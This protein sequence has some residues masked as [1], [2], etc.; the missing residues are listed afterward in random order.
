M[1]QLFCS[2]E[3]FI[4]STSLP[5]VTET[6]NTKKATTTV[7]PPTR[8]VVDHVLQAL[9]GEA[10]GDVVPAVVQPVDPVVLYTPVLHRQR[11]HTCMHRHR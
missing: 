5:R 2:R 1:P 10:G 6:E 11:V 3:Y 8:V 4:N 9:E 7:H